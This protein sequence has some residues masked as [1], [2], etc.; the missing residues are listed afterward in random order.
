MYI[1]IYNGRE[2]TQWNHL[3]NIPKLCL[4]AH[5]TLNEGMYIQKFEGQFNHPNITPNDI[6]WPSKNNPK[7][8][9]KQ[10]NGT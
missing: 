2:I 8:D 4:H 1:Y 7:I 6:P 10:P 9:N 3:E 5:H